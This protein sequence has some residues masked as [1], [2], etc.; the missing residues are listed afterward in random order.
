MAVHAA[1][2]FLDTNIP[3]RRSTSNAYELSGNRSGFSFS[4]LALMDQVVYK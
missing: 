2:A 1:T 3:S 4:D